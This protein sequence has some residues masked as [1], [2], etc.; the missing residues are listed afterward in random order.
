MSS[1]FAVQI[2]DSYPLNPGQCYLHGGADTPVVDTGKDLDSAGIYADGRLYICHICAK[3]L[4]AAF[5]MVTPDTHEQVIAVYIEQVQAL[6]EQLA[7][8]EAEVIKYRQ[9]YEQKRTVLDGIFDQ[10]VRIVD[11]EAVVDP[12][13]A[14][15]D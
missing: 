1:I 2:I 3:E 15:V 5:G 4:G 8:A 14:K 11:R 10:G 6:N 9:L 12:Q 13:L 7:V